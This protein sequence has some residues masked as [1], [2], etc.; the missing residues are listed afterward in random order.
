MTCFIRIYEDNYKIEKCV[1]KKAEGSFCLFVCFPTD[2]DGPKLGKS[3]TQNG[4]NGWTS[5]E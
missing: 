3:K 1:E 2:N 5:C 4:V